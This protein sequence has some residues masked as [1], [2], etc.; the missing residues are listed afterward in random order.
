[1]YNKSFRCTYLEKDSLEL[2]Q[3]EL[4]KA[5]DLQVIKSLEQLKNINP[6]TLTEPRFV[7]RKKLPSTV[8]GLLF[9]AAEHTT[10]HFGQLLVTIKI[11]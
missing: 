9:H 6:E 3:K 4:L 11:L 1:M 7:G 5:F 2:Y 8:I 10:R